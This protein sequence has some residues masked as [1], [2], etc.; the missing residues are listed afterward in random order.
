MKLQF[1]LWKKKITIDK[2][3]N[4][5]S[6]YSLF[7]FILISYVNLNIITDSIWIMYFEY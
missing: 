2:D 7:Y 5:L 3:L 1:Q 4:K 6:T